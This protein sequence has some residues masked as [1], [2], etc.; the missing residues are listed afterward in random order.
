MAQG[1]SLN[2]WCLCVR[3]RGFFTSI[4][5]LPKSQFSNRRGHGMCAH[6]LAYPMTMNAVLCSTQM[7]SNISGMRYIISQQINEIQIMNKYTKRTHTHT[8]IAF[9]METKS[10][11]KIELN[12][13]K[14]KINKTCHSSSKH[15]FNAKILL[16]QHPNFGAAGF[17]RVCQAFFVKVASGQRS[18]PSTFIRNSLKMRCRMI[19]HFI[20]DLH[21]ISDFWIT[22]RQTLLQPNCTASAIEEDSKQRFQ[23]IK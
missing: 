3:E 16:A 4:Y 23:S 7:H 5:V 10:T 20:F 17:S 8:F 14:Q 9:K 18:V 21:M 15:A 22:N 11:G 13:N 12:K 1:N 6:S 19:P 2:G